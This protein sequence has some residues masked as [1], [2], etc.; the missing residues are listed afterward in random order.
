MTL[1][2][3]TKRMY[4]AIAALILSRLIKDGLVSDKTV[5][6]YFDVIKKELAK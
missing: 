4:D 3:K 5:G 2:D 1:D 6:D